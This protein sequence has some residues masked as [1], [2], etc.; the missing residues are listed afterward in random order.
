MPQAGDSRSP[1]R[2]WLSPTPSSTACDRSACS[3]CQVTDASCSCAI[4]DNRARRDRSPILPVCHSAVATTTLVQ[5]RLYGCGRLLGHA[6]A[7]AHEEDV[8]PGRRQ[9][10]GGTLAFTRTTLVSTIGALD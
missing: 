7:L 2:W 1:C 4:K 10:H 5:P 9:A 8:R 6:T 3:T